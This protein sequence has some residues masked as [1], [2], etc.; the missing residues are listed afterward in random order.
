M[1]KILNFKFAAVL[2][3]ASAVFV[4]CSKTKT[5]DPQDPD[6]NGS[7]RVMMLTNI[8][9]NIVIPAYDNFNTK[10]AEL[11]TQHAV[12]TATP[13][14]TELNLL[15]EKYQAAYIEW[16]KVELFSIGPAEE[17]SIRLFL[18]IYPA[19]TTGI[20]NN[21]QNPSASLDFPSSYSSQGFPAI[22]YLLNGIGTD[23]EIIASYQVAGSKEAAYFKKVTDHMT[24]LLN[25]VISGWKGTS[26]GEFINNSGLDIGSSTGQL[27]NTLSLHYERYIRSGKLGYPAG[28]MTGTPAPENTEALYT[29]QLAGELAKTA[30]QAFVD[31]FNGKG[32]LTGN[33]GPSLKSYLNDL[34]AKDQTSGKLLSTLINEQLVICKAKLDG[35]NPNYQQQIADNNQL[36]KDAHTELQKA[37]KMIKVD[38]SSAMSIDITYTDNDGD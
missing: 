20:K 35:L 24:S 5:D 18:N 32:V 21:I 1:K 4:A 36:M 7:N 12:F 10:F 28:V 29:P 38:L 34:D 22:D 13:N 8:V 33:E 26:R 19:N 11:K 15:R 14:Q 6:G 9:D 37:V 2:I 27:V 16:Q 23:A 3:T 31:L 25:E 17:N 30:H